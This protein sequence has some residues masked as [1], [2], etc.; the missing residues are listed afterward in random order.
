MSKCFS[1]YNRK[2][3]RMK[4]QAESERSNFHCSPILSH[5]FSRGMKPSFTPL[6]ESLPD[7]IPFVAPEAIER[8]TGVPFRVRVGANESAFGISPMARKAMVEALDRIS[9][10]N[11]PENH[12]LRVAL[13]DHQQISTNQICVGAG[14]D[15]LL[16]LAVRAFLKP[17]DVTV[18]SL[19]SY[20]TF[21]YHVAGFGARSHTVP[22]RQD[23]FND[24]E[25]IANAAHDTKAR[26]VYLANP[27]NP[28]GSWYN[29]S[30]LQAFLDQLPQSCICILDE[31]YMEFA[32]EYT[33]LSTDV[34]DPRVILMRTF[35]KAHGLAG[36][37][38]GYAITRPEIVAAFDKIRL[39]FN[40]NLIAQAGALASLKD[41]DF[42]QRVVKAVAAGRADYE[43]LCRSL[44]LKTIPSAANFIAID[45]GTQPRAQAVLE[46][47]AARGVF[48]RKPGTPPLDRCIRVTVGTQEERRV[49]AEIF[50]KA[51]FEVNSLK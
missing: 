46:A 3:V 44:G 21:H 14:I 41:P 49:F 37:R 39:Q 43:T 51:L 16:G 50:P 9:H 34:L 24:L 40:V 36:A 30:D 7:T 15:D 10:Y 28:S 12:D 20:P 22:Y 6:V 8:Q 17:G 18:S 26:L 42:V 27:D 38:V 13:A 2:S 31:A 29:A 19:G 32:P 47:L 1:V 11:D 23:G 33:P 35:S 4:L 25:F 45:C 48:V 5:L